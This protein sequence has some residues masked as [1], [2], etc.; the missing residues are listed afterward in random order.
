MDVSS[1]TQAE[2]EVPPQGEAALVTRHWDWVETIIPGD[3]EVTAATTGALVRRRGIRRAVDLLRIVLAYTVCDWSLRLVGAWYV[4]MGI[5]DVSDVAILNRLRNSTAWLGC[6][7]VS[8]LQRRRLHL[9]QQAGVRLRIVDATTVSR[10]GSEGTDWRVHLSLDL[11][12]LCLDGIE[13]TDAHGGESLA[14]FPGQRGEIRVADRGYAFV[15]SLTPDLAAETWLVVRMNWQNLPLQ[16][17]Q[18]ARLDV[19]AW[20]RQ[21]FALPGSGPHWRTWTRLSSSSSRMS[22]STSAVN[23]PQRWA[24]SRNSASP[25]CTQKYTY[26]SALPCITIPSKPAAFSSAGQKPPAC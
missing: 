9:A 22:S 4:L 19:I 26:C 10:P 6:L 15:R 16:D 17:E 11:E 3:L 23:R 7:I 12:R 2:I 5:G 14:R 18:G 13:V 25:L 1:E 8:L 21:T 20:L 24:A